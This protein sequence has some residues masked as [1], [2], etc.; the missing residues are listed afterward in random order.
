[1]AAKSE[2]TELV[3]APG[4][5]GVQLVPAE[6]ADG[7]V[8][9]ED[10]REYDTGYGTYGK[11]LHPKGGVVTIAADIF[12]RRL[13]QNKGFKFL[14]YSNGLAEP[15]T[16]PIPSYTGPKAEPISEAQIN[17]QKAKIKSALKDAGVTDQAE[18]DATVKA[19]ED[20]LRPRQV[21]TGSTL[22]GMLAAEGYNRGVAGLD[23]TMQPAGPNTPLE[24]RSVPGGY[25]VTVPGPE[26]G[27]TN[28][29]G[30]PI[31]PSQPALPSDAQRQRVN[32]TRAEG[33]ASTPSAGEPT[34]PAG[35]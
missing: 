24:Q 13:Y 1:M 2:S 14:G 15:E 22:P 19:V 3:P 35:A 5:Y 23:P 29:N 33:E 26:T 4:N 8:E 20:R 9:F 34:K 18:V 27:E 12:A 32:R 11:Y 28:G 16:N 30:E 31:E 25:V 6:A 7:A 21:P 10:A 17:R